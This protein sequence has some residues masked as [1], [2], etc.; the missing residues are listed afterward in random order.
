MFPGDTDDDEKQTF[1]RATRY[2]EHE[3]SIS[4]D[5]R[6]RAKSIGF[7]HFFFAIFYESELQTPVRPIVDG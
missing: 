5:G 6:K 7:G 2:D 4:R 3:Y 1:V